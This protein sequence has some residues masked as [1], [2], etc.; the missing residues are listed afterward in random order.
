MANPEPACA[1]CNGTL[2]AAKL[3]CSRCG[4]TYYCSASCQKENWKAHKRI[5]KPK[6]SDAAIMT[7][8]TQLGAAGN[9]RLR[10]GDHSGAIEL[11][12]KCKRCGE[13]LSDAKQRARV[14][15]PSLS[16]LGS[17]YSE[18]GEHARAIEHHTQAL[19]VARVI[20][21]RRG[22]KRAP[23]AG[24]QLAKPCCL[25]RHEAMGVERV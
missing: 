9:E 25:Q 11:L 6:V 12:E 2:S 21:D 4:T 10:Q 7:E 18:M 5:C 17:A 20:G 15:G 19:A 1:N 22:D 13:R 14:M 8:A 24:S 23:L 3:R 16:M